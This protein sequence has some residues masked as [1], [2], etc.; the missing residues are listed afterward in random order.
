MEMYWIASIVF[1]AVMVTALSFD[2][3][4]RRIP[5]ALV[6]VGL[7]SALVL[8]SVVGPSPL[9]AGF[10]G[11][12]LALALTFPLFAL[13]AMGGGDVK[14]LVAVGAFMGP[15]GF[16]PAF[17][18]SAIAGGV[19]GVVMAVRRGVVVPVMLSSKDLLVNAA[20]LGRAGER[21][22]LDT[23]GAMKVPYGAAIA[24]GS[25]IVWFVIGGGTW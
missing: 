15:A 9:L 21:P 20:T 13:R 19:L 4:T 6:L 12:G 16:L 11:A 3:V 10:L 7:L 22:T 23:P 1:C 5:N 17:V 8:R 25:V 14:L 2:V 18:A 24:V